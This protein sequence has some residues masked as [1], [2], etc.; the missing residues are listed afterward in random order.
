MLKKRGWRSHRIESRI[1][2]FFS[3]KLPHRNVQKNLHS[4][5]QNLTKQ[6]AI[7]AIISIFC[8]YFCFVISYILDRILR[9][10]GRLLT[11]NH[12]MLL[13]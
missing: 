4:L 3:I 13:R 1:A 9:L 11:H 8:Y 5:S 10:F 6:S 7:F 12:I 2:S